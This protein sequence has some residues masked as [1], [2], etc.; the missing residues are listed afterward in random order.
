MIVTLE[1]RIMRT[2]RV[3]LRVVAPQGRSWRVYPRCLDTKQPE[4]ECAPPKEVK[5]GAVVL[6]LASQKDNVV[7]ESTDGGETL[8]FARLVT[9]EH[10]VT[11]ESPIPAA[12]KVDPSKD[13]VVFFFPTASEGCHPPEFFSQ[14][15]VR[16]LERRTD[17]RFQFLAEHFP[18]E[19]RVLREWSASGVK[20]LLTVASACDAY[21]LRLTY[22]LSQSDFSI[23]MKPQKTSEAFRCFAFGKRISSTLWTRCFVR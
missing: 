13:L 2:E 21:Q 16:L 9:S 5:G 8:R 20:P 19:D 3:T 7:I 14:D 4:V 12:P 22:R 11:V 10:T 6:R 18:Y 1:A 17:G 23:Q 15:V